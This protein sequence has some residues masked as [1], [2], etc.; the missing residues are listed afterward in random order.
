MAKLLPLFSASKHRTG[1]ILNVRWS[2]QANTMQNGTHTHTF[3]Y[4]YKF[5]V[6]AAFIALYCLSVFPFY[7]W[8]M[9]PVLFL[10]RINLWIILLIASSLFALW[11]VISNSFVI[12]YPLPR[13]RVCVCVTISFFKF[14]LMKVQAHIVLM[15]KMGTGKSWERSTVVTIKLEY[16]I[17]PTE[18]LPFNFHT[19][20]YCCT[21]LKVYRNYS[22]FHHDD[23]VISSICI[24]FICTWFPFVVS[25]RFYFDNK[26]TSHA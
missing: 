9:Y 1:N 19:S 10:I 23:L 24:K 20:D 11:C 2:K 14:F 22:Q 6:V 17:Q 21:S 13:A 16:F 15:K 12:S 5:K 3:V 7:R 18:T 25:I 8:A 26:Y 4:I